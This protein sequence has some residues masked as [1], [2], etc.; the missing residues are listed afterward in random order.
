MADEGHAHRLARALHVEA[1]LRRA[2]EGSVV[3][4]IHGA[5]LLLRL[6]VGPRASA[7]RQ[8]LRASGILVGGSHGPEVLRLMPPLL[9]RDASV[10]ALVFVHLG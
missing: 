3:R 4:R 7:L 5:G 2:L 6:R 1:V 9:V 10:A 8:H